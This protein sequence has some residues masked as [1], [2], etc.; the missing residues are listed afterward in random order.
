MGMDF[1]AAAEAQRQAEMQEKQVSARIAAEKQLEQ[2]RI[3]NQVQAIEAEKLE[4][5]RQLHAWLTRSHVPFNW[6]S[7]TKN[8]WIVGLREEQRHG[9]YDSEWSAHFKLIM[10]T[11]V[12]F[13]KLEYGSIESNRRPQK[14]DI[15]YFGIRVLLDGI[16]KLV[17]DTGIPWREY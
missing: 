2:A 3:L 11:N 16:I 13:Y 9:S 10:T 12:M 17:K 5:I 14:V 7:W 8:G 1:N 4:L 6:S 15:G